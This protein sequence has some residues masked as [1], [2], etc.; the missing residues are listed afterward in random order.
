MIA[1]AAPSLLAPPSPAKLPTCAVCGC[2]HDER[3]PHYLESLR[4]QAR[5]VAIHGRLPTR[6]DA[7]AHLT[8]ADRAAWRA[9]LELAGEEWSTTGRPIADAY[10]EACP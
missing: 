9:A 2:T 5:F 3:M 6:A 10:A 4:Y 8:R 7:C 1:K